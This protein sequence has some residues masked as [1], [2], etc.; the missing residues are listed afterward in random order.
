MTTVPAPVGARSV[1]DDGELGPRYNFVFAIARRMLHDDEWARDVAQTVF[2]KLLARPK[3]FSGGNFN[4]FL[5]VVT[6]NE[7]RD[8]LRRR[9]RA[10]PP[11]VPAAG[12]DYVETEVLQAEQSRFVRAA[13]A[14][15]P[16]GQRRLVELAFL[17]G[18]TH[19]WIAHATTLPL[20]T[21]KT[22]IRAGL[23]KLRLRLQP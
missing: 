12:D 16:D 18:Y 6:R 8:V 5:T 7:V 4:A 3:A 15:L 9:K 14:E 19:E 17:D 22:R 13:V 23:R 11:I 2:M 21:V 20:G 10:V 1:F